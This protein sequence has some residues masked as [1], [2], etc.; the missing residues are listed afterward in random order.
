MCVRS[1]IFSLRFGEVPANFVLMMHLAHFYQAYLF[2]KAN[3]HFHIWGV[4]ASHAIYFNKLAK[5]GDFDHLQFTLG[6]T[7]CHK[8]YLFW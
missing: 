8:K 3:H 4:L 7:N 5:M 6:L 1:W 2:F